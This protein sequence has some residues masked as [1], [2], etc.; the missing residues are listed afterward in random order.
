MAVSQIVFLRHGQTANNLERRIQGSRDTPLN[1]EGRRQ[2]SEIAPEIAQLGITRIYSS[3]LSRARDTAAAVAEVTG[4]EITVDARLRERAYGVWEGLNS[5][6]IR[7]AW[8][9]E[10]K[11]WRE[12]LEPGAPGIQT[13]LE[14]GELMAAAVSDAIAAVNELADAGKTTVNEKLLFVSHGSAIANAINVL[15]GQDPS[16]WNGLQGLD[17]CHWA[18]LAPR[19]NSNPAW[20]IVSYN[21][22]FA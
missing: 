19:L 14:N 2:A 8:P 3:D 4:L 17:N 16:V 9:T 11:R 15:L 12:G 6:E 21:R 7:Q 13:R 1:D 22:W 20:R 5:D 10:W 18:V